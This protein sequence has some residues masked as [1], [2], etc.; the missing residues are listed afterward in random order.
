MKLV[1]EIVV[2]VKVDTIL[3]CI[4]HS[5]IRKLEQAFLIFP[6]LFPP[7]YFSQ[8]KCDEGELVRASHTFMTDEIN[9]WQVKKFLFQK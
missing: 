5:N 4:W 3:C 9:L 1:C 2:E 8:L 7:T 6:N